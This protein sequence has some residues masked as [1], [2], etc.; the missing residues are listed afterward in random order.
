MSNQLARQISKW[1]GAAFK[2]YL[3]HIASTNFSLGFQMLT[4]IK[5]LAGKNTPINNPGIDLCGNK[6]PARLD[7]WLSPAT[8]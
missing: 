4:F 1:Q 8:L 5:L 7:L 3:I 6:F 2:S